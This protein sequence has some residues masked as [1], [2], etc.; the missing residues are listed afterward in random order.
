MTTAYDYIYYLSNDNIPLLEL[1]IHELEK[2]MKE[3]PRNFFF[4]TPMELA[5]YSICNVKQ[6]NY[7]NNYIHSKLNNVIYKE[8]IKP[9]KTVAVSRNITTENFE[10][11]SKTCKISEKTG[12]IYDCS[13]KL[14]KKFNQ[15]MNYSVSN[16]NNISNLNIECYVKK[17]IND[18]KK[19]G[20]ENNDKEK[21]WKLNKE[22]YSGDNINKMKN[23]VQGANYYYSSIKKRNMKLIN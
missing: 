15:E 1:A 11:S 14:L 9:Y 22:N 16:I 17:K 6:N 3:N 2:V 7:L 21:K 20:K 19:L 4:Q 18:Y 8:N 5:K 23:Y 10:K 12:N 13:N